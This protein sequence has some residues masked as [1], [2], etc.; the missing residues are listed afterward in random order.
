MAAGVL[1]PSPPDNPALQQSPV[2][3]SVAGDERQLPLSSCVPPAHISNAYPAQ[4]LPAVDTSRILHG[5]T[6][7]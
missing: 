2:T 4:F 7:T 1:W 3:D 6:N 5:T